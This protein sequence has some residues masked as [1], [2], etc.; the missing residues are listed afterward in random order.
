DDEEL[1]AAMAGRGLGTPATRAQIIENLIAEQYMLREGRELIPTAKAFSLLTLLNGLGVNE[2]TAPELTGEW[3]WK[4]GRIEKGEMSRQEFMREIA[5]MTRHI[6]ERAQSYD[7]DTI[8]GD[9]GVLQAPCP[10]CG[11]VVREN[12][13]KFQ[14]SAC[15]FSLWK[16]VAGRQFEPEE[17]ET[18]LTER[19]IGPLVGFRNKMGRPFAASLKLNDR[20]ESEFD[21]GQGASD[22]VGDP[23]DFS[24]QTPL[25]KCPKCGAPVYEHGNAYVCEKSVG[26]DRRCAFRSGKIILQQP[27]ERAQIQK[28]LQDGRTD[29]LKEFVS[30]RT[31]RKFSAFLVVDKDG[32][33]GFEFEKRAPRTETKKTGRQKEARN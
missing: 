4:L 13:K 28:L 12:Y 7:S 2:L 16:I 3:E 5:G 25:G 32:K 29:L 33:V 1:K 30:A 9:F 10:K 24:G 20:F 21:F 26:A 22:D 11:G 15:D 27:V 23:A 17:I 14:C 8:P 19:K 6:V 31:R 18:L